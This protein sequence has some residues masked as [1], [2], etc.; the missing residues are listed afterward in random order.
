MAIDKRNRKQID[1]DRRLTAMKKAQEAN[2]KSNGAKISELSK[3]E[4]AYDEARRDYETL[5]N[6][7]KEEM[8]VLFQLRISFM[9]PFL[10]T[11]IFFQVQCILFF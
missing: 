2:D 1:H 4:V 8:P 11:L 3:A 5:N 9:D 7:I 6:K 10:Q